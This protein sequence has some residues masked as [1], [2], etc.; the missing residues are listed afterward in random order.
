MGENRV[1]HL[2]RA[3]AF[4]QEQNFGNAEK[5]YRVA[6]KEDANDLPTQMALAE[7]QFRPAPLQR[8]YRHL[9]RG[10]QVVPRQPHYL[11]DPGAKLCQ[12]ATTA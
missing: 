2:A 5:E 7:T 8:F 3:E 10:A 4:R 6:L 9:Q 12:V 11:C 1:W